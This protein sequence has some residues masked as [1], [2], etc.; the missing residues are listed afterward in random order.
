[1]AFGAQ[2]RGR[3]EGATGLSAVGRKDDTYYLSRVRFD[4]TLTPVSWLK[5]Y[6][7]AQDALTLEYDLPQQ[8][9]AHTNRLDLRQGWLEA[10]T[11]GKTGLGARIGRQL[12]VYGDQRLVGDGE[13]NNTARAF[14]AAKLWFFAPG[15]RLEAFASS[16]VLVEQD[17]FDRNR[18]EEEQFYGL[19]GSSTSL[20]PDATLE[21]FL[22]VKH[23]EEAA[24]EGGTRG[25][26]LVET[27]GLRLAGKLPA[28]FD[29]NLEGALQSGTFA[30]NEVFAWAGHAAFGWTAM[31]TSPKPR[32]WLEYNAASGDR[33]SADGRK[34]TFDQLY[35]TNH[36]RYGTA[37]LVGW[38]NMHDAAVG[39]EAAPVAGFKI[40]VEGHRFFLQTSQDA[41]YDAG[42]A[43]VVKNTG[44][45]S[46]EV[47]SEVDLYTS[48]SSP[49]GYSVGAGFSAFQAGE[50]LAETTDGGTV[51]KP[52]AMWS[53]KF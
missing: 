2:L 25:P 21:P 30:E 49:R 31:A 44:V 17:R 34:N 53:L 14:D 28:R 29:Y 45:R 50:Y 37:D 3:E 5:M 16:V 38:K 8:P 47:G 22:F 36:F 52:Y 6:G 40:A 39:I 13:W 46:L 4:A 23:L 41:L 42:G 12:L 1:M 15:Y 9:L 18:H 43:P 7:Q 24:G 32:V 51:W 10:Q 35:P 48:W 26:A 27:A 33:D 11:P 20:V 19:V